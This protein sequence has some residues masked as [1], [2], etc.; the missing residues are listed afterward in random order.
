[1]ADLKL[2]MFGKPSFESEF[3]SLFDGLQTEMLWCTR[4]APKDSVVDRVNILHV[5]P[6]TSLVET[7]ITRMA[8]FMKT[9]GF[10]VRREGGPVR[11]ILADVLVLGV[12]EELLPNQHTI[13]DG[14]VRR[15]GLIRGLDV[16]L[17]GIGVEVGP[18]RV[19]PNRQLYAG[20]D[21]GF[22]GVCMLHAHIRMRDNVQFW[23]GYLAYLTDQFEYL[24]EYTTI[25]V[26]RILREE[27]DLSKLRFTEK[28]NR[29]VRVLKKAG[30]DG[31]DVEL[32]RCAAH[33]IRDVRN[34]AI[35]MASGINPPGQLS[36]GGNDHDWYEDFFRI[37][38]RHG[39]RD[40]LVGMDWSEDGVVVSGGWTLF[41]M[42]LI[43]TTHHWLRDCH[44]MAKA[45]ASAKR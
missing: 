14:L 7:E 27:N 6:D 43:P 4:P 21:F 44:K 24:I 33:T 17:Y 36:L 1:M 12:D 42:R 8:D 39:R 10:T 19:E 9:R 31:P 13:L 35:H 28:I 18:G 29:F 34:E 16:M 3:E 45:A 11:W 15:A 2:P 30:L 37:A 41:L 38:K 23:V 22:E 25:L 26:S 20:R 40:L 5:S 32:F